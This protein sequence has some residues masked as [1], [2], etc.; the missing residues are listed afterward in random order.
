MSHVFRSRRLHNIEARAGYV[1]Q[2]FQSD[3]DHPIIW[4]EY[5]EGDIQ[6]HPEIGGYKTVCLTRF[7]I[8]PILPQCSIQVRRGVFQSDP[9]LE[10]LLSYYSSSGILEAIPTEDPGPG[11]RPSGI[12]ALVTAAVGPI[13]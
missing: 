1:A 10:T 5:I 6:N 11:N 7:H 9:I 4:R 8:V 12:L 2:L 3:D 13:W